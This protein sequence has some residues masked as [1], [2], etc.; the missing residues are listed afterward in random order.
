MGWA[1]ANGDVD[2][3]RDFVNLSTSDTQDLESRCP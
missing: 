1:F 3:C 2:L